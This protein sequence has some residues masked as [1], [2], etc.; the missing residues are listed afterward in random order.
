M[1]L[2]VKA[3][4]AV[5]KGIYKVFTLFNLQFA[6]LVVLIGVVLYF[7]GVF[8]GGGIPIMIFAIVFIFSI[9]VAVIGTI[10][11]I[12]NL[13]K[14]DSSKSKKK[15]SAGV[16][17]VQTNNQTVPEQNGQVMIVQG[18]NTTQVYTQ[19]AQVEQPKYYRVKQ[20]KN[21]VMAEY[22]NRYELFVI[23][24]QGLKLVRTDMK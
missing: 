20:N 23:T 11:K 7:C 19:V 6:L 14:E 3:I 1:G 13:G 24:P 18:E 8:E 15:K 12:L 21:Y 2:I 22:S 10:N 17:V 5:L 4:K 16:Q 9:F